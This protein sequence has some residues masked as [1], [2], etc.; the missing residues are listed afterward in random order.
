MDLLYTI[1]A[2]LPVN[3]VTTVDYARSFTFS[4]LN[5]HRESLFIIVVTTIPITHSLYLKGETYTPRN[6]GT[7][8]TSEAHFDQNGELPLAK[9]SYLL[10]H[11][12][13]RMH[14]HRDRQH[15]T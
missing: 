13:P 11:C 2:V 12:R 1:R 6:L 4:N 14:Q 15:H 9:A 10:L 8:L 3:C 5:V 7:Q